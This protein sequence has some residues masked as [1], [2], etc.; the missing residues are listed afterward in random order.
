MVEIIEMCCECKICSVCQWAEYVL[1]H[2]ICDGKAMCQGIISLL[3]I[4]IWNIFLCILLC[5]Y[6]TLK[7]GR[8][9]M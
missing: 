5:I 3:A 4:N 6:V 1:V 2:T 7:L 9:W 8:M